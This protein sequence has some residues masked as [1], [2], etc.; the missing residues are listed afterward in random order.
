[1]R[2]SR[3]FEQIVSTI[4]KK[5][6][7]R[8]ISYFFLLNTNNM[9]YYK[10]MTITFFLL[11]IFQFQF[12]NKETSNRPNIVFVMVDDMNDW[13]GYLGG[14]GGKVYTPNIDKLASGGVRF[15]NAH[16][17]APVCNPSR[18]AILLGKSPS[19]TGLYNNNQWWKSVYPDAVTLPQYF[20]N[21]GY[22]TAGAGKIFHH[23]PGNNPPVSWHE[24]QEQVFDDPWLF[25]HKQW[26][27]EKYF[28]H[29]GYRGPI[30]P[31]PEWKPLNRI[32]STN[33]ELDWG[34]IPNKPEAE[35]G[36]VQAV[37]FAK[38]FLRKK[39]SKPFF[40]TIGIYRP[41][42]PW[43]VPQKYFDL[44]PLDDVLLPKVK[45]DDLDDI[46]AMGRQ[47]ARANNSFEDIMN[48]GKWK[49]AVRAYLASISFADAQVGSI[50]D[51]LDKS[52]YRDNTI[53][54]F[55]SDHGFHLGE[56]GHWN[57]QTL[58]ER[59]TR[60]PFVIKTPGV[61]ANISDK[62]VDMLSV[63]PTLLSLAGLPAKPDLEGHDL[64]PLLNNSN[65]KW[66]FPA[67]TVHGK[68]NVAIRSQKWRYIRYNDGGEELYDHEEDPNEWVNLAGQK[69]YSEVIK[70]HQKWVPA[71]FADP[72]VGK[73]DWF[74][75]PHEY[76]WLHRK[77]GAFI[78]GKK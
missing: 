55:W 18:N 62:P 35:Y 13:V 43:H 28:L 6:S 71:S 56:K 69:K 63:Y 15:L 9:K 74:F 12:S 59:C 70:A 29:Y 16:T 73:G 46:P 53:I 30:V 10:P 39:H 24:Y 38:A 2:T 68:G 23:T 25:D 45:E 75:D 34:A 47:M 49:E 78:D 32:N 4:R 65:L 52:S 72:V 58:W 76:T 36:D 11:G 21:H 5:I 77:T 20:K 61:K 37:N 51:A 67:I 17:S 64:T 19:T 40:L 26:D 66:E 7:G 42:L 27:A 1:M 8:F 22:H 41:H 14:Y 31:E 33:A 54:V 57:K 48:A 3:Y 50:L 60:I 44:Y